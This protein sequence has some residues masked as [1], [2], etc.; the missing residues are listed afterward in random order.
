[1]SRQI[2]AHGMSRRQAL[3]ALAVVGVAVAAGTPVRVHAAGADGVIGAVVGGRQPDAGRIAL[4]LP[5][6]P[7]NGNTVPVEVAVDSPMSAD[8]HVTALHLFADGNRAPEVAVF[9]FS[10][11]AGQARVETRVRLVKSQDIV[12]VAEFSDGSVA[13]TRRRVE[14][15]TDASCDI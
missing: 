5:A 12:A 8:H 2:T 13:L 14:V 11:R 15:S 9:H 10:P 4:G 1:M 3:R 7:A 6:D